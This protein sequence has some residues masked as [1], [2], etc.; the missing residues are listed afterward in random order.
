MRFGKTLRSPVRGRRGRLAV[1]SLTPQIPLWDN[2]E[3]KGTR[4]FDR[5]VP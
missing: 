5:G 2:I 3:S 4:G 1:H